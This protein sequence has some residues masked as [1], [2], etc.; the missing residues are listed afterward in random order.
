MTGVNFEALRPEDIP[1]LQA[2][3]S[4]RKFQRAIRT[5]AHG[6]E[7]DAGP[8]AYRAQLTA[9]ATDI[10]DAWQQTAADISSDIREAL[11]GHASVVT[12]ERYIHHTL[13]ELA[14]AAAVLE[15]G[16][17]FDPNMEPTVGKRIPPVSRRAETTKPDVHQPLDSRAW[18]H[19]IG[20][21]LNGYA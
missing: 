7:R 20:C 16:G 8:D 19:L 15:D 11:I 4:F 5:K 18:P 17:V 6:I 10:I 12:T 14:K 1:E 2:S 9:E 21:S 3:K 13:A